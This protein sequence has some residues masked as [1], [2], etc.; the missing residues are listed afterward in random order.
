MQRLPVGTHVFLGLRLGSPVPHP[1]P[2]LCSPP[3]TRGPASPSH[4]GLL[5]RLATERCAWHYVLSITSLPG[6]AD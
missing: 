4:V 1:V 5:G 6:T 2:G 3:K